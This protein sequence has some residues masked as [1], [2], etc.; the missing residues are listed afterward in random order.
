MSRWSDVFFHLKRKRGGRLVFNFCRQATLPAVSWSCWWKPNY[1]GQAEGRRRLHGSEILLFLTHS[2]GP[3]ISPAPTPTRQNVKA[4]D[5]PLRRTEVLDDKNRVV[6]F[7][8]LGK[9]IPTSGD[10]RLHINIEVA[11]LLA[12]P[13]YLLALIH[14]RSTAPHP[15]LHYGLRYRWRSTNLD[16]VP[17]RTSGWVDSVNF[18]GTSGVTM[19]CQ[20]DADLCT[21]FPAGT[22]H[23]NL[24]RRTINR[25]QMKNICAVIVYPSGL[26]V[27]VLV[28]LVFPYFLS[29]FV[30]LAW[31]D[32]FSI[33]DIDLE[34]RDTLY[35]HRLHCSIFRDIY[36]LSLNT[37][38]GRL[39]V[40]SG[41]TG[42]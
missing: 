38:A 8:L 17:L 37:V 6:V 22:V 16:D 18:D 41:Q 2:V 32:S 33:G 28:V 40:S 27:H 21:S 9:N 12:I 13:R 14:L 26:T 42:V 11:R 19:F 3:R 36:H 23:E 4:V 31:F 30:V 29:V 24:A 39:K 1:M 7:V 20:V 34:H 25:Y 5:H 15:S 35:F 10:T